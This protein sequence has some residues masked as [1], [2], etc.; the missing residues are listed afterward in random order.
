MDLSSAIADQALKILVIFPEFGGRR[1]HANGRNG[2][3]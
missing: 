3:I 1:Y 2:V